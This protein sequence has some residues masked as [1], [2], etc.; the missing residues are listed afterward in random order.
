MEGD[1]ELGHQ[2]NYTVQAV[3]ENDFLN[4]NKTEQEIS[5]YGKTYS[6]QFEGNAETY[7]WSSKIAP[8]KGQKVYGHLEL[9]KSG[10]STWFRKDKAPET[11]VQE[12][13][14]P[15]AESAPVA[16]SA[17][18]SG[19]PQSLMPVSKHIST[20]Y[21][22]DLSDYPVRLY[23]GNL[24]YASQAGLNLIDNQEDRRKYLEYIKE[25]SDELLT[26]SDNIR[27]MDD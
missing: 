25:I 9:A 2:G 22:K 8:F 16:S 27:G 20:A 7:I 24:Q 23:T 21:L 15:I 5:T 4:Q 19:L 11:G 18:S 12:D 13:N 26:Y 10:K 3:Q 1:F 14:T 6:V 17:P